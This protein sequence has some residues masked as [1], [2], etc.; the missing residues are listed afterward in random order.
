V[1]LS[2]ANRSAGVCNLYSMTKSQDA[3]RQITQAIYDKTGNMPPLP[4]IFR[5]QMAPIVRAA[6]DGA[7][8]LMMARWGMQAMTCVG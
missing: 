1:E 8:E 6:D 5:D 3:I 4:G 2:T 7:R